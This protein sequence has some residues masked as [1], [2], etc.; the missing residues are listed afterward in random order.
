MH[1][2][3]QPQ[4]DRTPVHISYGIMAVSVFTAFPMFIAIIVS[5]LNRGRCIDPLLIAHY[6]WQIRTFWVNLI[7][8]IIGFCLIFV[9]IGWVILAINQLWLIYR[10]A[11]GWYFLANDRMP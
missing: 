11:A 6:N 4:S 3:F 1:T 10:V 7:V 5:W 9:V 2:D 8:G